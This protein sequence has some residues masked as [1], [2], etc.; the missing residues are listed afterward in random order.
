MHATLK[1][2]NY[3]VLVGVQGVCALLLVTRLAGPVTP[4]LVSIILVVRL[5]AN[6]RNPFGLDGSDQMH[7]VL[8]A[9]LTFY[10]LV[11]DPF[12]KSVALW[13]IGAQLLLSYLS[14]GF[15]KLISSD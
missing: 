10:Y 13:F 2:P 11:P 4:L 1:Y 8:F 5:L 3:V 7:V 6:L 12:A 9:G 14:A 15:A